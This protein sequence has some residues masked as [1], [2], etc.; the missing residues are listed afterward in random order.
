R[1]LCLKGQKLKKRLCK[2]PAKFDVLA[3]HPINVG[4]PGRKAL[5]PDDISTPDI[6]E[7]RRILV[8]AQRTG[9]AL[10]RKPKKPIWA[11]EIWWD[12]KPPDPQGVPQK[13]HARWMAQSFYLLWKQRVERVVWF[14][15]RDQAA[16]G[17]FAASVQ[18]G[19]YTNDG[20]PKL[21]RQAFAFP[22]V[23]DAGKGATK[24]WGVAPARGKVKVERKRAGGW[25]RIKTLK[26][27][28]GS[29]VFTGRARVKRGSKLR[30][31]QGGALSVPYKAG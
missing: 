5:N 10:P 12:S 31:V 21:A 26:A 27:K 25:K 3:H 23:A 15:I 17:N 11:T 13:R 7:L 22:F 18:S 24:L 28:G 30:A 19:L 20:Q 8:K 16:N 29:R 6:G 4:G 2:E 14:L 1:V 9:R